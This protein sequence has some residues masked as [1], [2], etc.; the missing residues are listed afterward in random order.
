[1]TVEPKKLHFY[2]WKALLSL[3]PAPLAFYFDIYLIKSRSCNLRSWLQVLFYNIFTP[4]YKSFG[5][6]KTKLCCVLHLNENC[7]LNNFRTNLICKQFVVTKQYQ[8]KQTFLIVLQKSD[9]FKLNKLWF[10]LHKYL[11]GKRLVK[12]SNKN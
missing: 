5:I 1:M 9:S 3:S 7:A 11:K 8:L 10:D 2:V 6:I 4:C 12:H